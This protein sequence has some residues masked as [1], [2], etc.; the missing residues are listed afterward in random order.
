MAPGEGRVHE[1]LR[2]H[3]DRLSDVCRREELLLEEQEAETV[4]L[5]PGIVR[6]CREERAVFCKEVSPGSAR[7]FR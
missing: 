2:A 4:E 6:V 7:L 5:R 3:R 1:C